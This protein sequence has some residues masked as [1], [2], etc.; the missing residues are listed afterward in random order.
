MWSHLF[1]IVV[2]VVFFCVTCVLHE[3]KLGISWNFVH[4][5]SFSEC[6]CTPLLNLTVMFISN[7]YFVLRFTTRGHYYLPGMLRKDMGALEVA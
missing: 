2:A 4:W 7:D 6:A 5:H 3:I 1:S